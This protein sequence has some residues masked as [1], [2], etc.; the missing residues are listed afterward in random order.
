[1]HSPAMKSTPSSLRGLFLAPVMLCVA[2]LSCRG[3]GSEVQR[4]RSAAPP[5][6]EEIF[7][8]PP[9]VG[10][11]PEFDSLSADGEWLLLH[12][13]PVVSATTADG[14]PQAAEPQGGDDA[15]TL[16]LV[17]VLQPAQPSQPGV[18]LTSLLPPPLPSSG[19]EPSAA[20]PLT[21]WSPAGHTL[22]IARGRELYL[23]DPVSRRLVMVFRD[24]A[25]V[26]A[27]EIR[28]LAFAPD[29]RE[30][31]F[32]DAD[33][34]FG[35]PLPVDDFPSQC[36]DTG[37]L[38]NYSQ[39]LD[40]AA[41]SLQ[42]SVDLDTVF[43]RGTRPVQPSGEDPDR[44]GEET[45]LPQVWI[46]SEERGV[47]LEGM[48]SMHQVRTERLSPD[49]RWV[50]AREVDESQR[51][52]AN[53]V[54]QWLTERV[55]T[56]KT[57]A[58]RADDLAP[59]TVL[60]AWSATAGTRRPLEPLTHPAGPPSDQERQA[61]AS[62]SPR[63]WV[64]TVGWAPQPDAT[65]PA[66]FA[67]LVISEDHR[68]RDL[69]VFT[70][71]Y[72]QRV[73]SEHDPRWIGGPTGRVAWTPD[74]RAL[75]LGSEAS[76][77]L[78]TPG[79]NQLFRVA[80]DGDRVRQLTEV[81]GE[82]DDFRVLPSGQIL[83]VASRSDPAR[84]SLGVIDP[85]EE[86]TGGTP[87]LRWLPTPRGWNWAPRAGENADL[88]IF[89][90]QS[91]LSPGELWATDGNR[92][93]PLTDTAPESFRKREWVR[94]VTVS[95]TAPDGA[96]VFA[97]VWLP[98]GVTLEDPGPQ[99]RPAIVFAH[100]AGYLQNVTDSM[101]SYPL[102]A[103]FHSR[104]AQLG[105]PVIDVDY[106]GSAGYGQS[107]RTDVQYHLGGKDLDDIHG[108]VDLLAERGLVD[109]ERVG[110]YGGS[111]GGFLTLM[112]LFT[113]PERWA[114]GAALRSVTDWRSYNP[115]YTQPRLGRP[116]THPEAYARSSPIDLVA[117]LEDP[118]YLFHGL[119]DGNVFAQDTIRLMEELIDRGLEFDAM[120]YPSQGHA[121]DEGAH[122]LDEYRR[123]ERHLLEALNV[124]LPSDD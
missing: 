84:R 19:D 110:I 107:F 100:G 91:L 49:G 27:S 38:H 116:S 101:T 1:M 31:R 59:P 88:V 9:I 17:E 32:M 104:L 8:E 95:A 78:T 36:K 98:K 29:G 85:V 66:R 90:H 15:A 99:P 45:L 58:S 54:P 81:E 20:Q 119:E 71:G 87:Q 67:F 74:G 80:A 16:R 46:L 25:R 64:R 102:N 39:P 69:W 23:L 65:A 123:I 14:P 77:L 50:I 83:V 61:S 75:I 112:A 111:Y 114:A 11:A 124:A 108:I 28:S 57:R 3:T 60:W 56:R 35:L 89:E 4:P 82:V 120:L 53:L 94:P 68:T 113:A 22:A 72:T 37:G 55:T 79:H 105:V 41:H 24:Q 122:W 12:W 63:P 47:L 103:L 33:D 118:L 26:L 18:V 51:P 115:S 106:R 34:L 43:G 73:W 117:G 7:L 10:V 48:E 121:F 5:T 96:R 62:A 42:W 86:G 44:E 21:T 93:W 76:E 70:E 92:A 52:E 30:L 13:D 97:H 40:G 109:P 2:S 6:L